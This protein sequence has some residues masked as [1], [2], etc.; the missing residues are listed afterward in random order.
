M[1]KHW[2]YLLYVIRHKYFVYQE[3]RKLGVGFWQAFIHDWHKFLPDEWTP[4]ARYF[5]GKWPSNDDAMMVY[6]LYSGPTKESVQADFDAAW[7]KHQ[8]RA[9]HHWQHWVLP[10]DS[11]NTKVLEMPD[12]YRREM[13]A[14]WRGMGRA[15]GEH[16]PAVGWYEKNKDK[17][18][19]HPDTR[20]WV[21]AQLGVSE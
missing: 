7:L 8:H 20:A 17:M 14:D 18:Q 6:P 11:G 10:E 9:P 21:E 5:Y 15:F 2:Q 19:L 1:K 16:P 3:A 12:K 13:L 4:Y